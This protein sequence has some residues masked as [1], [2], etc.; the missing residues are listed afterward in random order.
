MEYTYA[1]IGGGIAGLY[2]A[3][4]LSKKYPKAKIGLFEKYRIL[5]GR[6]ITFRGETSQGP[7][8]WEAGAGR[9][10]TSHTLVRK[11]LKEYGLH[12]MPISSEI[13]WVETYGSP[14]TDNSFETSLPSWLQ[15]IKRLPQ[16]TLRNHTLH[17]LLTKLRPESRIY[18]I[19]FPY[20]G[21][22]FTL[23]ADLAIESFTNEMGTH[24]HYV[25]CPEGYDTLI[26]KLA[27]DC[28]QKGVEIFN[29][30]DCQ[31][32]QPVSKESTA[33]YFA[34]GPLKLKEKRP[35]ETI[36]A[37]HVVCALHQEALKKYRLFQTLPWIHHVQMD[38]L[39]R[40]Y[41]VFPPNKQGKIWFEDIPKFVTSTS[42]RYFIP[43][44]SKKGV[45]MISY[46]DGKDSHP[47]NE[48]EAGSRPL[49]S[50]ALANLVTEE[51]RKL[52]P[53][54]DIPFPVFLKSHPWKYGC[55]YWLP[56]DYKPSEISQK[57]LQPFKQEFPNLYICGESF[58][59]RQAWMEGALENTQDLLRIL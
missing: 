40:I 8:Q 26:N 16:E 24:E 44:D 17:T 3:R 48:I 28:Q 2:C 56:G 27:E 38:P 22:V 37:K 5:G 36:L 52:F 41:A 59:M 49:E 54:K 58:S 46:T 43:I 23:R 35:V 39:H 42:I 12:E 10:H 30:Y 33:L 34:T 45:T 19:Q 7:V 29:H 31:E 47:W 9:I 6:V 32:I 51:C 1:I 53:N 55:T 18:T 21:E 15:E 57:S 11:L 20:W 4:E 13:K 50:S 25:I 14:M